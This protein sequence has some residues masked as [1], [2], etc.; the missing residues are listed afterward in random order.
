MIPHTVESLQFLIVGQFFWSQRSYTKLT[1]HENLSPT[2]QTIPHNLSYCLLP[3]LL[4]AD[5]MRHL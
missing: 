1:I 4:W 3:A 2:I 5:E